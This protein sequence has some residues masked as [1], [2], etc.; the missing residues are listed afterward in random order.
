MKRAS[1]FATLILT[2]FLF[3]ISTAFAVTD[4]IYTLTETIAT[5][6]GTEAD[7]LMEPIPSPAGSSYP[8][9]YDHTYGD[10]EALTYILPWNF[11]FYGQR[12]DRITIDTNGNIWFGSTIPDYNI[13]LAKT[14]LIP[15]ISVWN[16]DLSSNNYGGVFVRYKTVPDQRVVIEW[17]TET[18]T[19]EGM[20]PTS[21]FEAVLYRNG[22]IRFDYNSFNAESAGDSGSGITKS[23][24]DHFLSVSANYDNVFELSGHSYLFTDSTPDSYH[25]NLFFTGGGFGMITTNPEGLACNTNCSGE[26]PVN[27]TVTLHP[28][29]LEYSLFTGWTGGACSGTGNC[30]V[31][32]NG[33]T[34]AT[35]SFAIDT[36]RYVRIDGDPTTYYPSIQAAYNA[37]ADN[38]TIKLWAVT[39]GEDLLCNRPIEITLEGGYNSGYSAITGEIMLNGTLTIS[40]GSVISDGLSIK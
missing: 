21:N 28:T 3:A 24:G 37:A 23:D 2:L 19:D 25:L 30:D 22:D 14:D 32:M 5:W 36:S 34:D 4:G 13:D 6:E 29:P 18:Y 31:T 7:L 35:A 33:V 38:N 39:Y 27:S 12:Y 8:Y 17:R 26:F 10:E 1:T 40:D 15:V 16:D 20:E 9:D 11:T